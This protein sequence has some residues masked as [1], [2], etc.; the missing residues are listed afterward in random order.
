[1]SQGCIG[2][3]RE[4]ECVLY[5]QERSVTPQSCADGT[6]S[7]GSCRETARFNYSACCWCRCARRPAVCCGSTTGP[8]HASPWR[9]DGGARK[10]AGQS[11][12]SCRVPAWF[13][14]CRL[15]RGGQYPRGISL[16]IGKGGV[17]PQICRGAGGTAARRDSCQ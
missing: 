8:A 11:E 4:C 17:D 14:G 1:M 10:R 16:V 12:T 15:A 5:E 9:A 7:T 2:R 6:N 3:L 13:G